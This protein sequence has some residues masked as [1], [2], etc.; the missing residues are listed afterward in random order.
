MCNYCQPDY[1]GI[2]GVVG[3]LY[4]SAKDAIKWHKAKP[5]EYIKLIMAIGRL[6][7]LSEDDFTKTMNHHT[8]DTISDDEVRQFYENDRKEKAKKVKEN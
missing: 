1:G 8:A 4:D 3:Y 6:V 5:K 7:Y 2:G